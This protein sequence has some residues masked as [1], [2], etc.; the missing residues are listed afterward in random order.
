[1]RPARTGSFFN[2]LMQG[3]PTPKVEVGMGVTQLCWT[4]RRAY[5]VI[6]VVSG[7]KLVIQRDTA[8]PLFQGMT[9]SQSYEYRPNLDGEKTIIT[10]RENGTWHE[11]GT[12]MRSEVYALGYRQEYYD[13]TF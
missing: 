10:L 8:I 1:M 6:E 5:T 4:D 2:N 7:K 9:D 13:Y 12:T 11:A 3:T